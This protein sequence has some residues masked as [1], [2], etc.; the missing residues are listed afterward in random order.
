MKDGNR[1]ANTMP[2]TQKIQGIFSASEV[3]H[4][5]SLFTAE[6]LRAVEDLVTEKEGRLLIRCQKKDKYK[7][8]KP[9][10]IVRQL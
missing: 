10:E 4:G 2:N 9:E 1:R 7:V 5:I 8:A 6:E 3:K